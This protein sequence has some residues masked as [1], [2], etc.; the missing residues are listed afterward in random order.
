MDNTNT[1]ES[2]TYLAQGMT[3]IYDD[4]NTSTASAIK[5]ELMEHFGKGL[6][7]RLK[8]GEKNITPAQ[9]TFIAQTFQK[10]GITTPPAYDRLIPATEK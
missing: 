3:N 6:Y 8:S 7:Y 1:S 4:V 5:Q 10:H 9:Q 2:Q